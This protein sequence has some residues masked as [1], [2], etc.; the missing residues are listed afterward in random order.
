MHAVLIFSIQ[1][2]YTLKIYSAFGKLSFFID[3]LWFFCK[4]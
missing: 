3:Y 2:V 4:I 1:C